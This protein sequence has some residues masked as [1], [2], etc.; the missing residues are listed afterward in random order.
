MFTSDPFAP[1]TK[2]QLKLRMALVGPSGSGKTF[3]ALKIAASL[4]QKVAVIDT[5]RGSARKYA[6]L[7]KFSVI[8]LTDFAP[9][10]YIDAI[11]AA[12]KFGYDVLVIDSLTHAWAGTGGVLEMKDRL[13]ARKPNSNSYTNWR[14]ITPQHNA[15][16]D[17]MLDARIHVI[18]T[19][20]TKMEYVIEPDP[21]KPGKTRVRKVGLA[22]IQRDGVEYEFDIVA[23]MDVEN[24]LIVSKSRCPQM[25]GAVVRHPGEEVA[26]T[27]SAWL[28]DGAEPVYL[29]RQPKQPAP[30]PQQQKPPAG[31]Q[32]AKAWHEDKMQAFLDLLKKD[33]FI[34][35]DTPEALEAAAKKLLPEG[36][37]WKDYPTGK[38]AFAVVKATWQELQT[39][40]AQPKSAPPARTAWTDETHTTFLKWAWDWFARMDL[41]EACGV[42]EDWA[43]SFPDVE[44]AREAVIKAASEKQWPVNVTQ[45]HY[46]GKRIQ[47]MTPLAL[48]LVMYD[49]SGKF[50]EQVGEPYWDGWSI[51]D[52]KAQAEAYT[53]GTLNIEWKPG[54]NGQY[55]EAVKVT[56]ND[57]PEDVLDEFFDSDGKPKEG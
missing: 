7:F 13:D 18:A 42:T 14:E 34:T 3:S 53:I 6:D 20:R 5:E 31:Q 27:L 51:N 23:D 32:A 30:P 55:F 54:R 8:E 35:G 57:E 29:P 10:N 52:W 12:E 25:T 17:A 9:Q 2:F 56:P 19:M 36:K 37:A 11:E 38:E 26:M 24:T 47:F 39:P 41:E 44:A 1:A 4:G 33:G 15:L 46:N 21:D 22:P 40:P 49:R 43:K 48:P 45:A 16:V 50:R 28:T